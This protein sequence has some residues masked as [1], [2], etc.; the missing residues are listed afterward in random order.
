MTN[1]QREKHRKRA[2]QSA[3][4]HPL[5]RF[6]LE[7]LATVNEPVPASEVRQAALQLPEYAG[8]SAAT[9]SYHFAQLLE[10]GLVKRDGSQD[11]E[12]RVYTLTDDGRE[13]V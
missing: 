5:R 8:V 1:I 7:R 9:F 2:Q 11:G 6:A 3:R 13:P 12:R 10:A 4:S